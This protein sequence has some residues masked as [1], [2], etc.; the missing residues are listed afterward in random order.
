MRTLQLLHDENICFNFA[1]VMR[2]TIFYS[3]MASCLLTACTPHTQSGLVPSQFDTL[4]RGEKVALYVL[5]NH[6]GMEACVTNYGGRVVSLVVPDRH[7]HGTSV[8]LGFDNIA[9]YADTIG[10]PSDFGASVGRYANRIYEGR[11]TL[12]GEQYQLRRN[13]HGN[14]LHGGFNSGWQNRVYQAEQQGDSLLRLTL[15]APDGENGFPGTV[16]AVTT[17]CL[18]DDNTL[19]VRWEATTDYPTIISQTQHNYYNLSGDFHTTCYDHILYVNAHTFVATD[20]VGIPTGEL[21][22]VEGTPLDYRIDH[23]VG[24]FV[25]ADYDQIL[26]AGGIDHNYCINNAGDDTYPCASLYCPRT[27]IRMDMYTNEPGLQIYTG[28]FL[29]PQ[30]ISICMESQKYP[31][32]PNHPEWPSPVLR[33]GER[34]YSHAAYRFSTR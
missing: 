12:D 14:C 2:N 9:S 18:T 1:L 25:G 16:T 33:P 21:R 29:T 20:S 6:H 30:H 19:D 17:Y 26:K 11:Y 3:I 34:Y 15:V 22:M 27:G 10:S 31:D 8:V 23:A 32:S 24:D 13:D 7:G 4:I 5:T 28:N